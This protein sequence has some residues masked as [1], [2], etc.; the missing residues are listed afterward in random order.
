MVW[1]VHWQV[2]VAGIDQTINMRAYLMDISVSD[3]EGTKSDSCDLTSMTRL[4]SCACLKLAK[5]RWS[6]FRA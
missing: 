6:S 5:R 4:A 3:N 2:F 1:Q